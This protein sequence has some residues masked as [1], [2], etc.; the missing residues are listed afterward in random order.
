[1]GFPSINTLINQHKRT[2]AWL[3]YNNEDGHHNKS[4]VYRRSEISRLEA[5]EEE[6]K[7]IER[8]HNDRR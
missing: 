3:E 7:R 2:L 4:I 6:G 8:E 1:M 5:M